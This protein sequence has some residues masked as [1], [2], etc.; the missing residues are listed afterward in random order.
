MFR[1]VLL[2]LSNSN[3]SAPVLTES[4]LTSGERYNLQHAHKSGA[5]Q[6]GDNLNW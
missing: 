4:H 2:R 5:D 3:K 6:S 1:S